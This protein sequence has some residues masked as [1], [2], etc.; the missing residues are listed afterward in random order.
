LTKAIQITTEII[1]EK[2][3]QLIE[4]H[5]LLDYVTSSNNVQG[6]IDTAMKISQLTRDIYILKKFRKRLLSETSS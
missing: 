2:E 1:T 4:L 6:Q 3:T 5:K